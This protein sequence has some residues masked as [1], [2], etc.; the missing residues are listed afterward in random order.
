MGDVGDVFNSWNAIKK[1]LRRGGDGS[2]NEY[3]SGY[4]KILAGLHKKLHNL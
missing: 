2:G 4:G 1:E 3:G